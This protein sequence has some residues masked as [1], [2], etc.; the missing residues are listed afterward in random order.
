MKKWTATGCALWIVGLTAF[1]IGLNLTGS[2]KEWITVIGSVAFLAGLGIVGAVWLKTR[3]VQ[4]DTEE[5]KAAD[6]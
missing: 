1:V 4:N 3:Y 2:A 5:K 6:Q